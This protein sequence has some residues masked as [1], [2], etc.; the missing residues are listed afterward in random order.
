MTFD[1]KLSSVIATL[2]S[3]IDKTTRSESFSYDYGSI[4]N[5]VH[6][7]THEEITFDGEEVRTLSELAELLLPYTFNFTA[8]QLKEADADGYFDEGESLADILAMEL[9]DYHGLCLDD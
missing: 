2:Q 4:S 8:S 1:E 9:N 3:D 5:A 7:E 6:T